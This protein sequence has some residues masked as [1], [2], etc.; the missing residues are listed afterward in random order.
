MFG[1]RYAANQVH[2][3]V[4][5][6][7]LTR[8]PEPREVGSFL[9]GTARQFIVRYP[10]MAGFYGFGLVVIL[11]LLISGGGRP[12]S[13][14]QRAQYEH[15]MGSIDFRSEALAQ[16]DYRD[17]D[18]RFR[19]SRGWFW[20]CD[21]ICQRHKRRMHKAKEAYEYIVAEQKEQVRQ[22]KAVA[23]ITSDMGVNEMQSSFWEYFASAKRYAKRQTGWDVFW[24]MLRAVGRRGR[25][26]T[27][28]EYIVKILIH[29]VLNFTM[30]LCMALIFFVIGLWSIV[31]SYGPNPA[32][33]VFVFL[34]ATAAATAFVVTY[35]LALAG[36]AAGTVYGVAYV[37][38]NQQRIGGAG[39]ERL[40][41]LHY[42]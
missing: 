17:A 30:G 19:Q 42:D 34:A 39:Q 35:L 9:A 38:S 6:A 15:M 25:D 37:A 7:Q 8:L 11:L 14:P 26:E 33:A 21:T 29:L 12:M 20:Q 24:M 40:N 32:I 16:E 3:Q 27:M 36:A 23:G 5:H 18:Y 1:R 2:N 41:R 28:A 31:Y 4:R 22:A 10:S 13:P